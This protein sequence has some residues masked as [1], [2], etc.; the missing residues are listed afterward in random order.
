[1]IN[2]SLYQNYYCCGKWTNCIMV[3]LRA[4]RNIIDY[5]AQYSGFK[6]HIFMVRQVKTETEK[7]NI[8]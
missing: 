8:N 7:E 6:V 2:P 3:N 5:I 4:E 1:M